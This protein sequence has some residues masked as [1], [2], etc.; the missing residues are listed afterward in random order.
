MVAEFQQ[1]LAQIR[2]LRKSLSARDSDINDLQRQL[3][4]LRVE[5]PQAKVGSKMA[6]KRSIKLRW[7]DGGMAPKMSF[8]S[9]TADGDMAYFRDFFTDN[10][11]AHNAATGK[12]NQLPKYPYK[13]FTL[14]VVNGVLTA[15]GGRDSSGTCNDTSKLLSLVGEGK[16][17]EQLPCMPTKRRWTAAVCSGKTLVVIG[18]LS[19]RNVRLKTV[20]LLDIDSLQWFIV[21]ELPHH[22]SQASATVCG[23]NL[24][25]VGGF[26]EDSNSTKSVLTCSLSALV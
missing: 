5:Q 2:D 16:W 18:G 23:N 13:D 21:S 19:N 8:G 15:V 25:L 10:V 3:Q 14:V 1:T 22:L 6:E 24:Y 26:D 11:H 12:W 4:H 7:R 17:V 20:E 9:C